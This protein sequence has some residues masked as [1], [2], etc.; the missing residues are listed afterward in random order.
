[1]RAS[2]GGANGV[3]ESATIAVAAELL[4]KRFARKQT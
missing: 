2:T 1:M 3:I 4:R